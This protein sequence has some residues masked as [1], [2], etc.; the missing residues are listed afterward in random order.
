MSAFRFN[1]P[2][3]RD[4]RRDFQ[5]HRPQNIDKE[6]ALN[7]FGHRFFFFLSTTR[8]CASPLD[9]L[10]ITADGKSVTISRA[11]ERNALRRSFALPDNLTTRTI[12]PFAS[13]FSLP[14]THCDFN[15]QTTASANPIHTMLIPPTVG[16]PA[17][18]SMM[19]P[20]PAA[21]ASCA[22][23]ACIC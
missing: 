20:L 2:S 22:T 8:N 16:S 11:A 1:L 5:K 7:C 17:T 6:F 21:T 19:L 13:D 3:P 14:A 10:L 23:R 9:C 4:P 15:A 18:V 12:M